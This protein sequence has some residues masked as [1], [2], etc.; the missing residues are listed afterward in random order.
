MS[1]EQFPGWIQGTNPRTKSPYFS[2]KFL[3]GVVTVRQK[4]TA[5]RSTV[6]AAI[7]PDGKEGRHV[8]LKD[9]I[10]YAEYQMRDRQ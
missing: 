10:A 4:T 6:W 1:V 7:F 8:Y 3:Q 2:R 5:S 9:A